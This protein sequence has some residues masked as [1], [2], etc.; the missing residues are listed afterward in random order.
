MLNLFRKLRRACY[1]VMFQL[2]LRQP[3]TS[4]HV[5]QMDAGTA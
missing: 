3:K 4:Y 2:G 5:V 1:N